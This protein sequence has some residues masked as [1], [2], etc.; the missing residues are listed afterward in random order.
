MDII[1]QTDF[2]LAWIAGKKEYPQDSLTVC[3]KATYKLVADGIA[4]Q[5][6]SQMMNGDVYLDD[7][8]NKG[9]IYDSDFAYFKPVADLLLK[10]TCYTPGA[11]PLRQ[12]DVTF[13]VGSMNKTL[14]VYGSR[15]AS[16]GLIGDSSSTA[17][18]FTSMPIVYENAYGGLMYKK[19][20]VGKGRDKDENGIKWLHNILDPSANKNS[21]AGFGPIN[22]TWPSRIS[23][24]GSYKGDYMEKR[25]P[26][27]PEDFDW[28]YFNSAPEDMQYNGYLVGD[29]N[30][31]FKNLH[32]T[33]SEYQS[34]LP[35]IKPRCFLHEPD[36]EEDFREVLMNLDTLWVD[37]DTEQVVLVWRG[38]SNIKSRDFEELSHVY[39]AS[40]KQAEAKS[41]ESYKKDFDAIVYPIIPVAIPNI[42]SNITSEETMPEAEV[43]ADS[44]PSSEPS[45]E[46]DDEFDKQIESLLK[47]ARDGLRQAGQDPS[48][49][50]EIVNSENPAA[51]IANI[52]NNLGLDEEQG[53][54]AVK[55]M[56]EN[57]KK[58]LVELGISP[59]DIALLYDEN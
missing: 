59:E 20:P 1:N 29:E 53:E 56:Q 9:L 52:F 28:S 25:W 4:L 16:P 51:I 14:T 3:V 37:M 27:F 48:V 42:V 31:Y 40:E 10:S 50:D 47:Q 36:G 7:D 34:Q 46:N 12:C 11:K 43:N 18:P 21:I 58:M 33:I 30:L 6:D 38:V 23:K 15:Y 45:N 5:S 13:A 57:N 41:K 17:D 54:I 19:N 26:W 44:E 32:P 24:L 2:H 35:G 8:I 55:E 22:R 39:L 49:I